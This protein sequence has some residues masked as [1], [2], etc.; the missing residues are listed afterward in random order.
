[1]QL[2]LPAKHNGNKKEQ[3]TTNY[4]KEHKCNINVTKEQVL[5]P[6][7]QVASHVLINF[8]NTIKGYAISL[9]TT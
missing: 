9:V 5:G 1:M 3:H 7:K 6:T 4:K 8:T 2:L